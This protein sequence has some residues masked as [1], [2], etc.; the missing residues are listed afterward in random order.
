MQMI[1]DKGQL[2]VPVAAYIITTLL[3]EV[4]SYVV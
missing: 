1:F 3:L 4:A 2:I